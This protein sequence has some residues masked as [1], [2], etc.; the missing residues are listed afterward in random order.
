[1]DEYRL[2]GIQVWVN[3]ILVDVDVV[4][5]KGEKGND[6]TYLEYNLKEKTTS[7]VLSLLKITFSKFKEDNFE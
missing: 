1:M 4:A 6:D 5:V 7:N 3:F 2:K